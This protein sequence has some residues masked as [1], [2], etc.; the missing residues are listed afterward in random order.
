MD[1]SLTPMDFLWSCHGSLVTVPRFLFKTLQISSIRSS[2]HPKS[3]SANDITRQS[4]LLSTPA[5]CWK[6]SIERS[7]Q[8]SQFGFHLISQALIWNFGHRPLI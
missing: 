7:G 6:D 2:I 1:T 5:S 8:F 4:L 3:N